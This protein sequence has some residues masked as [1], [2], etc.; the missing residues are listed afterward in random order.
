V[1]TSVFPVS[2]NQRLNPKYHAELKGLNES[3]QAKIGNKLTNDEVEEV[4]LGMPPIHNS[5]L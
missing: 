2:E 3:I 5:G 1:R 4:L